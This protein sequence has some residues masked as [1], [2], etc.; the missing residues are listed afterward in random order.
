L[1]KL[2]PPGFSS[3][4]YEKL[5][6]TGGFSSGL[7]EKNLSCP[8]EKSSAAS[9]STS[10]G[11]CDVVSREKKSALSPVFISDALSFPHQELS[12]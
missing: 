11:E 3:D 10:N 4:L 12:Q 8:D 9:T 2:E 5:E 7:Y 6:P 1:E